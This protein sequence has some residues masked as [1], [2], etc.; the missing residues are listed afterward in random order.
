MYPALTG[1]KTLISKFSSRKGVRWR[2]TACKCPIGSTNNP[3]GMNKPPRIKVSLYL[4]CRRMS[5]L[6]CE[7]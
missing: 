3:R 1:S 6:N 2:S 5:F 7:W 4:I